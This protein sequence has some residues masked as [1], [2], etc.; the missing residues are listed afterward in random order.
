MKIEVLWGS[1]L[2]N[3]SRFNLQIKGRYNIADLLI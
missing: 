3:A 1:T 2:G